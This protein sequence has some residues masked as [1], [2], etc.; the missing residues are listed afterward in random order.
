MRFPGMSLEC[1]TGVGGVRSLALVWFV[2][3]I[4]RVRYDQWTVGRGELPLGRAICEQYG[5]SHRRRISC[6]A[7]ERTATE[8]VAFDVDSTLI[9]LCATVSP[10]SW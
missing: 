4:L 7:R 9:P 5:E 6:S 2:G 3:A 8:K 10:W 1:G